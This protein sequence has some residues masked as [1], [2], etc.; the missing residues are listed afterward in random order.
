MNDVHVEVLRAVDCGLSKCLR[1]RIYTHECRYD[2][3]HGCKNLLCNRCAE[4]VF[5]E[6]PND[7]AVIDFCNERKRIYGADV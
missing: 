2:E 3:E 1:C 5:V 4:A 6:F 7:P